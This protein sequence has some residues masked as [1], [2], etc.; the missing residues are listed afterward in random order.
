M[1]TVLQLSEIIVQ[2]DTFIGQLIYN[3]EVVQ[4][5]AVKKVMVKIFMV[6]YRKFA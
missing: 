3:V 5:Q 6:L 2:R 1:Q 4:F